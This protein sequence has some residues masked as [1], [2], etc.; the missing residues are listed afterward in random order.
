MFST[1]AALAGFRLTGPP[2]RAYDFRAPWKIKFNER[3][4]LLAARTFLSI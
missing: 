3:G 4:I 1:S 2:R